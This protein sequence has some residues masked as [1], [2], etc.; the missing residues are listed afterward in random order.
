MLSRFAST[1][2]KPILFVTV[3]LC[4]IGAW[5]LRSFPVSILPDIT[6]PRV[7]VIVEAGD[8]PSRMVEIGITRPIEESIATVPGVQRVRSTTERGAAEISVDFA[9]G[10]DMLS[11]QQQVSTRVN[12]VRSQLPADAQVTVERMNPTVFPIYGLSLKSSSLSQAD[13]W[14]LANYKLKPHLARI[15][16]VARVVV[17]GGRVPEIAV[18]VSPQQL[19]NY[20]LA[21]SDVTQAITN[22]NVVRAT[23]KIQR[24]YQQVEILVSGE[25]TG[26]DALRKIVVSRANGIPVTLGQLAE[27]HRAEQDNRTLVEANGSESVLINIVRQPSANTVSVVAALKQ[28]LKTLKATLPPGTEVGEF[29]DQSVLIKEAVQSVEEAVLIGAGLAVLVL[30]LFLR[31][32][33]AT[34][35]TAAIIPATVLITFLL[36]R[37]AGLSLNLMT[38]GALAIGIGLVI[39]DAIVVVENVFRHLCEGEDRQA[40]VMRAAAEISTPMISSTLTTVVV[41]LPLVLLTGVAGAFFTALA[42]TLTIAVMVSLVLALLASP[43]L[44]AAFLK[45]RTRAL[46]SGEGTHAGEHGPVFEKVLVLYEKALS[47]GLRLRF[48]ALVAAAGIIGLTVYF[49]TQLGSGFMPTMDEGAFILDYWTPPGT[50]LQESDR[51]LKMIDGILKETP[52]ISGF[53]RRTGTELGFAITET[54]RGD[55]AIVLK[56]GKRRPIE[57]VI[58][59][60]RDRINK[61]VPGVDIDF[62]QVLQDLIGDL[63]GASAPVEIKLFGE[64]RKALEETAAHLKEQLDK[65]KGLVDTKSGVVESGP[66]LIARIQPDLAGRVGLT[67]DQAADQMENSLFGTVATQ[68]VEGDR[69]VGVRVRFASPYRSSKEAMEAVPIRTTSGA[70]VPLS[71]IAKIEAVPGTTES[72]REDQR[73]VISVTAGLSRLDLGTAMRQ[74]SRMMRSETLPAGV[75]YELAGQ[76]KSE[77]EASANLQVVLA[78]AVVL[79]L[80]VMVFQFGSFTAPLTIMLVMPLSLFG[81]AAA[82]WW[83]RIPLN[84]SSKMGAVM[85]VGIVVKNGILLLEQARKAESE[86]AEV[87]AAVLHAGRVRLRPILMTTLTALLGLAPLALGLGAGAEMQKPLAISVIGGLSFSTIFTLIFGPILYVVIRRAQLRLFKH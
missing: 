53:S 15:P 17:Q 68:V 14:S 87:E 3:V 44:C 24:R 70:F 82:L 72:Y 51:L 41:F 62:S 10:T 7:V 37:L 5:L 11:A 40:A 63:A 60:V 42:I 29:Y 8:R 64:D 26:I 52:E 56:G 79:V 13:L 9:W 81:V 22:A 57:E 66:E 76:Y 77:Q 39:D 47:L 18:D 16:G 28:D 2:I 83:T 55:Y 74:V 59:D 34:L 12:E 85:L 48:A 1:H 21:I 30:L 25:T 78:L 65:I 20:K 43:S 19:A 45:T 86:G 33:R 71:S 4:A 61:E 50:S 69:Q 80:G 31:D 27:I 38:L 36:M 84:V 75:T 35:V 49:G 46:P 67:A 54:N 6:F 58:S 23:G 32:I 73:R